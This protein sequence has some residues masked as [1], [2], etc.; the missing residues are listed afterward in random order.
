M[1]FV[2]SLIIAFAGITAVQAQDL[3][4]VKALSDSAFRNSAEYQQA[5]KYQKDAL[6][7]LD[8]LA[9]THP[10][11]VKK[12][13]QAALMAKKDA[14]MA[15][16]AD[17]SS[18]SL[19][20]TY[21]RDVLGP[22]CDKHTDVIDMAS[23]ANK[24][25]QQSL[26]QPESETVEQ[27]TGVMA[28]KNALF[29]FQI[30]EEPSICYLQFNQCA[31]ARTKRNS[32]LPR[33]D[34]FLDSMFHQMD[35]LKVQTLVVDVQYNNGGSSNLCDELMARLYPIHLLKNLSSQMR[36]SNL[37]AAYNPRIAVA[38]TAWENEGHAE[39]LYTFP[40]RP[41]KPMDIPIFKGKV[42]WVQSK[43]TFSSAGILITLARDNHVG[44]IIG[45]TSTYSPSHY[46][47]VL[48]YRLPNTGVLGSISCKYFTRPDA[49]HADDPCL[50]PDTPLNLSNKEA[51]WTHI[52]TTY[53]KK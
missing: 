30:F 4:K 49:Q 12:E 8:M 25:Q 46:G 52:L 47:E 16:C 9:D 7:F 23:F 31:D 32:A 38:K 1:K 19:F 44:E 21:L 22:L 11:Y 13:R 39:E 6:L 2:F 50:E 45:E 48:P 36:F 24:K 33:F 35:S 3:S 27:S 14:L 17:C 42:V 28:R 37:A 18:D 26:L 5:N 29:A 20:C 41:P 40:N 43:K 53:T 34:T 51:A 10:Y 15:K